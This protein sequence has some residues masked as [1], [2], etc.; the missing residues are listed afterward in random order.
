MTTHS[1]LKRTVV[2]LTLLGML[3]LTGCG[4]DLPTGLVDDGVQTLAPTKPAKVEEAFEQLTV[5][6]EQIET[7]IHYEVAETK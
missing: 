6:G 2:G 5:D 3:T 7:V 1:T 4:T